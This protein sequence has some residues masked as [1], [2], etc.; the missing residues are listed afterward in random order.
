[1]IPAAYHGE[2]PPSLVGVQLLYLA[3]LWSLLMITLLALEW[4]WRTAWGLIEDRQAIKHPVTAVRVGTI[5]LLV[6]VLMRIGPD[7]VLFASWPDLSPA[8]RYWISVFDKQLET[9]SF[10]PF[11]L[12]WLCSHLGGPMVLYQLRRDPIPLNLWPTWQQF[13]RPL[14]IGGGVTALAFVLVYAR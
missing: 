6:S 13:K 7:V 12:A 5:F 4:L 9:V 11:S 2:V 10:F 1:M 8:W 14:K 3:V